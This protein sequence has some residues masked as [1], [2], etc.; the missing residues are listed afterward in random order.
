MGVDPIRGHSMR[1]DHDWNVHG[2]PPTSSAGEVEQ[3]PPTESTTVTPTLRAAVA[4]Q[5]EVVLLRAAECG[6]S[7]NQ[8]RAQTP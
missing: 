4:T 7:S 3:R 2:V 8:A 1:S 5:F 6:V